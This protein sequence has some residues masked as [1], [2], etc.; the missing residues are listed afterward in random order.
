MS[1]SPIRP[2]GIF[3]HIALIILLSIEFINKIKN[4]P[5]DSRAEDVITLVWF[6]YEKLLSIL[7]GAGIL[8]VLLPWKE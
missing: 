5:K 8:E 2:V 6:F 1:D 4:C 3:S 7:L